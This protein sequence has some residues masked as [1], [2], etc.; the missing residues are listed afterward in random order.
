LINLQDSW[1]ESIDVKKGIL[2]YVNQDNK[3]LLGSIETSLD[4]I[5]PHV[6]ESF[7]EYLTRFYEEYPKGLLDEA[8]IADFD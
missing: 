3:N 8:S 5:I 6:G 2:S 1:A 4:T 7:A